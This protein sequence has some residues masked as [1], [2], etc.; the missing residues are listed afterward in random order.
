MPVTPLP[1]D[2]GGDG[3]GETP[4]ALAPVS[5]VQ[6]CD[7]GAADCTK[8]LR[9]LRWNCDGSLNGMSDTDL[10]G[11]PYVP[12]GPVGDC[13]D[14]PCEDCVND[15]ALCDRLPDGECI[16]FIRRT[17]TDCETGAVVST[18]DLEL[19]GVTPYTV[20]GEV[21]DCDDCGCQPTPMCA[22][23]SGI[24]GPDQWVMPEGTESF[25]VSIACGPITLTDCSG[26]V[27]VINES[28]GNV[29]FSAPGT[30]CAPGVLCAPFTIDIPDGSAVYVSWLEPCS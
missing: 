11:Q 9:H 8:F 19:D 27:T 6:L 22:R 18:I 23:F 20:V 17:V 5:T 10:A 7:T 30:K 14:C 28:C 4:C 3:G 25:S 13:A 24:S 12:I 26:E 21:M 1:C 16:P 29:Q 2:C 15:V